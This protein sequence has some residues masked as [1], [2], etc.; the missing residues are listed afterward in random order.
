MSDGNEW[1]VMS[2]EKKN[3]NK[4]LVSNRKEE[5]E[6]KIANALWNSHPI[7]V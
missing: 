7:H 3:Q 6:K 2:I 1:G 4:A 5:K